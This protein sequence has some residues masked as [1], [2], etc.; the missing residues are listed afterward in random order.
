MTVGSLPT[1]NFKHKSLPKRQKRGRRKLV[2]RTRLLAEHMLTLRQRFI[3]PL[4]ALALVA[5][6]LFAATTQR[7]PSHFDTLAWLHESKL[8]F[9]EEGLRTLLRLEDDLEEKLPE[10]IE[11]VKAEVIILIALESRLFIIVARHSIAM[12]RRRRWK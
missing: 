12:A 7:K 6:G 11:E 8:E 4:F 1:S 9:L 10:K 5:V 2:R 3:S